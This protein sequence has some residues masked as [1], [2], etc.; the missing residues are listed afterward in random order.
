LA[1]TIFTKKFVHLAQIFGRN[2]GFSL[3]KSVSLK[4]KKNLFNLP[5]GKSDTECS[6][7]KLKTGRD[8]RP[9]NVKPNQVQRNKWFDGAMAESDLR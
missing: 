6:K 9:E 8:F 1:L 3:Q 2:Q 5:Y 4:I 7:A